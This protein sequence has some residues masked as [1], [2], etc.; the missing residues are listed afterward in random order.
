[1]SDYQAL[2]RAWRPDNFS[3]ICGQEAVTR[4]LKRQ[5][6]SGHVAHAYLFCGSRG[7]GK[8]TTAKVLARAINCENSSDGDPCGVCPVCEALKHE[9]TMD[10][11]EID[12]ASNNGVDEVR[13]LRERIAYP[14]TVGKYKVY[15]IDEVHMLSM[16]AFN[17][18][19]KTLEEPPKHAVFILATTEPQKL[20]QT[21][22][23]RCQ[24]FDFK[25]IA[26]D[27]IVSR[28]KVVLNGID[29]SADDAALDEIA[30]A[31]EGGM[32]D[33]LSLL[34]M[35][36]SYASETVTAEL[37]REALGA[38]GREFMFEFA[39][40]IE[41]RD[42]KTALILIDKAMR[43]GRDSAV[44]AKEVAT[45]LRTLMMAQ[46]TGDSLAELAEVTREDAARFSEQAS[47]FER[48][49][50]LRC[51]DMFIRSE[52]DMR[53][54]SSPRSILEACAVRACVTPVGSDVDALIERIEALEKRLK[55][56]VIQVAA[57]EKTESAKPAEEKAEKP[58]PKAKEKAA[59]P[60]K[61]EDTKPAS[62]S[63]DEVK[64]DSAMKLV[65]EALP[66]MRSFLA[67]MRFEKLEDDVVF[68]V[69]DKNSLMQMQMTERKS[70]L[71]EEKLSQ[72]FGRSVK[73][74]LHIEDNKPA[75]AKNAAGLNLARTFD[76]L[77]R[78]KVELID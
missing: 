66:S 78:D 55:D 42:A 63:E 53:W 18:L 50:L 43:D 21:V 32:R 69:F 77:G 19:L 49:R 70:P 51:M 27:V 15:I 35:C 38:V 20:P 22:L 60:P 72:A 12:A 11:L 73:I 7:T 62:K 10:V 45:H 74:K 33:A 39:D 16:S 36:L 2:Y 58:Q 34:D 68:A 17:A 13:A 65:A 47:R 4:T 25:R 23:S 29:R 75:P 1:M 64:F 40:A 37:V 9:N 76:I 6:V 30:R 57:P 26:A 71:I 44:F 3:D 8:T 54:V 5:I 61:T 59:V 31:A 67:R 28:L 48:S 52:G 14:P 46:L 41:K 24:R 56:G